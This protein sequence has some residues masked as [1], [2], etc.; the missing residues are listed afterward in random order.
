M[1][2]DAAPIRSSECPDEAERVRELLTTELAKV[3]FDESY[4]PN[5]RGRFLESLIDRFYM[6]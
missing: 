2:G 1:Q 5:E 6:R 4:M 3:G